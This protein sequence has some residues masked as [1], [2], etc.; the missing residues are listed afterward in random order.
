MP[1][2][3]IATAPSHT[4]TSATHVDPKAL[5]EQK[6]RVHLVVCSWIEAEHGEQVREGLG[7]GREGGRE[8]AQQLDQGNEE[9]AKGGGEECKGALLVETR[10][11]AGADSFVMVQNVTKA[12]KAVESV[13]PTSRVKLS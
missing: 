12:Q 11:R 7:E 2:T 1:E 6:Q 8:D 3:P 13:V 4:G 10:R 9:G 5:K